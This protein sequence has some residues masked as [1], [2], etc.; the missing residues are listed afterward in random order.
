[1]AQNLNGSNVAPA[2]NIVKVNILRA[3][4]KQTK[5]IDTDIVF[6]LEDGRTVF[7]RDGAVQS[8]LDNGFSVEFSDGDQV[9]GQELLQSAGSAEISSVAL[10][11]PQASSDNN[12]IV[13][14]APQA[15]GTSAAAAPSSGG[16]LK[17]WLA[18]GTPLVG[19]VLGGVLGGGGGGGSAA[20]GG[21]TD[22]TANVKPATPV[23]NVV[24]NDDKVNAAEKDATAGVAV[25]G[26]AEANASVTVNWGSTSKT[27]TADSAG[28]WSASFAKAEVPADAAGT[29]ISAIV[30]STAGVSSDPATRTVQ[31]D[32]TA[33]DAPVI[34]GSAAERIVGPTEK[35]T[36][37][38]FTGTAEAGSTVTVSFAGVS[39]T[40]V[41]DAGGGWSV[42]YKPNEVPNPVPTAYPVT[43]TARDA[44]GNMSAASA[45]SNVKVTP[46]IDVL[47][48]I[49]AGPV[50]SGNGLSVDIYRANGTLLV[51]GI[52]V[53]ADGSFIAKELPIVAGDVIFARVVD[54]TTAADYLDEATGVATDLNAVLLAVTVVE[55][56]SVTMNI[57]PL[58]TIAAIK[59]GLA[60][61]GSGTIANAAAATNAN[62][63]TAQAFGL[64]GIDIT[65]TS[66]VATNSDGYNPDDGLTPGE[67]VGAVLA[68]LSGL[69]SI[70]AG[71]SQTTITNLSQSVN[72]DGNKGQLDNPGQVLLM[73]G[74]TAAE[75]K[76]QGSLQNLISDSLA[77]SS[78]V[79]QV[80]INAIATDN[81]IAGTEV[82]NLT[83]SGTVSSGA[84]GVTVLM[85]TKTSEA[86]VSGT[87][88]SYTLS[89][90]DISALGA[91]GVKVIQA[92]ATLPNAASATASR[93]VT[94]KIA[95]PAAP[96]LNV[97]SGDNAINSVE[98]TAGVA[99]AGTGEVGSTVFLTFGSVTKNVLVDAAA[100]TWATAFLASE[101]PADG[102]STV[103]VVAKDSFGNS[104]AAVTRSIQI[105]SSAP[106][107]PIIKPVAGDDL[108]GPSEKLAGVQVQGTAEALANIS[109]TFGNFVRTAKADTLG[110]WSVSI[111][112]SQVPE[113]GEILVTVTQ[114]DAAGNVSAAG[115]R[116]VT[117]DAQ[118]PAK[119]VI[120]NVATD[121]IINAAEKQN[122]VF[123]RG[124][125][126][127]NASI[128]ITFGTIIRSAK[129]SATGTWSASFTPAQI[130]AD[131]T[132]NVTAIATD[133][134]GNASESATRSFTIDTVNQNL[135]IAPV[136][137]DN[138]INAAEK[139]ANVTVTGQAEPGAN[140]VVTLGGISRPASTNQSGVW[141]ATF[142]TTE[143]PND[144]NLT[145]VTAQS[146]DQ[147]GNISDVAKQDI[148]IDTVVPGTPVISTVAGDDLINVTERAG[149]I[150]VNGTAE[151]GLAVRVTWNDIV[152]N[153][154]ASTLGAWSAIFTSAE[155]PSDGISTITARA[156]DAAGNANAVDGTRSVTTLTAALQPPI[157]D[158][159]AGDD[160]I[161]IAERAAGVTVT[162]TASANA[163]VE[164]T[165][166]STTRVVDAN[167]S[168][169]W[170]AN[171]TTSQVAAEGAARSITAFQTDVSG[172]VSGTRTRNVEVDLTEPQVPVIISPIAVDNIINA[173]EKNAGVTIS[174]TAPI[175]T[176]VEVRI[177]GGTPKSLTSSG[178]GV[179]SVTFAGGD[180]PA[181]ATGVVIEA[182]TIDAAGNPSVW[183]G[184]PPVIINTVPVA[185]PTGLD[186][187][188]VDDTG[189]S[190]SDNVTNQTSALTISGQAEANTRVELFNG[191]T[192]LGST[193]ADASGAFSFDVTLAP[194]AR[195]I[196]AK[197]IDAVGNV[198][199]ASAALAITVDATAPAA[200]K[201][202]DLATAPQLSAITSGAGGFVINGA[203][204]DDRSGF[205]VSS[206]GD[207]NND[208]FDDLIIGAPD[209]DP[210][211]NISGASYVVFGKANNST[212]VNLSAIA[213][214]IG[215]FVIN[216]ASVDDN[217]G[218]SVSSAG[219]VNNDGFDD[220][221][222]G[223]TGAGAS[224]GAS[225]VVFGK[226]NGT[227]VNLSA[228][229]TGGFVI[230]GASADVGLGR[231]VSSAGDV[232]NDGYD[233][234]IIGADRT[235]ANGTSYSGASYV[236][237]GKANNTAVNLSAIGT[238]G[239]VIDGVSAD[240]RS[241]YSVSS[242]GDVNGDGFDDLIIGAPN[243]DL[244]GNSSGTSYVVFGKA[245]NMSVNLS[246]IASG[247]G[248]FVINGASGED[249]SGFSVSSAGDVNGDGLD[250]LIIGAPNADPNG[251]AYAGASYVVFGKANNTAPVNLSAI[252]SGTGGF[253]INGALADDR[254]GRSVGSAGDV[255][256]DGL[257]DLIIG[258]LY[259][260]PNGN[261]DA[262]ASYVV[263]GKA[264]GTPVNLSA[265]GTGGFVI[266]GASASDRSG[267][268]VSSAGDLNNDGFDDLIIGA[269]Y[270]DPNGRN[271]SGAS[272]V[273]FGGNFT[274]A[275][276][277]GLNLAAADD[278]GPSN[279]DNVTS[280]SSGLTITG[281]AEANAR[282]QLFDGTTSLGTTTASAAGAFSFDVTLDPGTRSIT[283]RATDAA[284]N[285][286]A[287]SAALAITV[288]PTA[289]NAPTGLDLAA[290]DD[291]GASNSDNVTSQSSG[292]T[293]SGQAEAN[294]RIELF[295]GTTSLGR[296]TANASGAFSL[297][298]TL[299]AGTR[300]ITAKATD[301]AGNV[302]AASAALTIT[303]DG[304]A[305][306]APTDLDLIAA[307][308][309]GASSTDN[310]TNKQNVTITGLAAV[311]ARV[312][313]FDGATS[314]GSAT[315][316]ATTGAFSL[317]VTL[318]PGARSITAKATDAS[319]NVSAASAALAI[320]V[321]ATA[322]NAP[323][324]L[325]LAAADDS[326][327]DST[328]NVTSQTSALTISGQAEANARVELFDGTTSL[329][330]TTAS[331]TGAFSLDVTLA[332][333]ARSI[334]AR[335][336]DA[337]GNV[338]AASAALA[339]TVDATAP[340][341]PTALDLAAADD[342]G[343]DSTDNV[344]SQTSALTISGQA[345]ANARVE[346]FNGTTSLGT[347]TANAS[348]A[349]SLD[350][351]LAAGA[352]AITAK[353][354][355]AA[356]NVSAA[357]AAL[358]ITVDG[359]APAAP[360][361]LDLAAAD[362]TG[363]SNSDNLTNQTSALTI[364]GQ[365]EANARVQLFDGTTSLGT[366]TANAS[367]AFSL[368]VT[369]AAGARSITAR[370]TD[371]AGNVGAAS[372][373]LAITVDVT[374]PDVPAI[375]TPIAVDNTINAVEKNAG[376]N[377]SGTAPNSTTVEVRI[378][379][380]TPK[381]VT[382]S[383][384]GAWSVTFAS[385]EIPADATGVIIEA[386]TIDTAGN[387]SAWVGAPPVII[388]TVAPAA[389][390]GLDLAA[391][392]DSGSDSTDN[393][394]NQTSALT[395][396]G[397]AAANALI[398]LFDGATSLGTA[399]ADA[400]TGAFSFDVTLAEGPRSITARAI[401]EA[402]NVSAASAALSV[403]ID[404]LA[405]PT[406]VITGMSND[407]GT[408]GD[409]RTDR[410]AVVL[411][412]TGVANG[413]VELSIPGLPTALLDV[414]SAGLWV[415]PVISLATLAFN[416]SVTA[417]VRAKDAAGNVSV[418]DASQVIT[419]ASTVS[420]PIDLALSTA[421]VGF[422]VESA[423]EQDRNNGFTT[424]DIN[425]DGHKDL[426]LNHYFGGNST[427]GAV[428]VLYG[429]SDWTG[430][431]SF[432]LLNL[433]NN[434]YVLRGTGANDLLGAGGSGFIGDLN[435]DGFGELIVGAPNA[436]SSSLG[437]SG[438]AYIVWGSNQLLGTLVGNRYIKDVST[439][440]P[441]EGF[442]FRGLTASE[443]MGSATLG[444]SSRP[445][446]NSDFNGDGLAD[447]FIGA[448]GYDKPGG[449][450]HGGI[451]VVFGRADRAY[452]SVNVTTGQQ[453]MTVADLTADKGFIIVG[454]AQND[455]VGRSIA[456]AG[457]VNGDGVTDLLIG[458][459][460][461]DRGSFSTAGAA[462]V[463]YGKKTPEGQ[464]TWSG[465]VN[466]PLM[467]GRKI[468]DL[469]ALKTEDGFM[470][471][472]EAANA[473]F[474]RS[475]EG[476]G[477][478]NGDGFGDIIVSAR[479][480]TVGGVGNA[481]KAYVIFG[482]ATG[483]GD[484]AGG[485]Q[486]L[487]IPAMTSSQ[488]FTIQG[489][490]ATNAR[491]G[492]SVGAAGDV[493]GDGLADIMVTSP[494]FVNPRT[495]QGTGA[496][497]IIYGKNN[498]EGWGQTV[499]T[500]SILDLTNFGSSDGFVVY[501][502]G[503]G[504]QLGSVPGDSSLIAP[505][506]LN[507]DGVDDLFINLNESD[508]G[509][510]YNN[511]AGA[512]VYGTRGFGGLTLT[513]TSGGD[514]L[515]GGG[516]ADTINGLGGLDRLSG[517][518]GNDTLIVGDASF[519]RV[520]GGAGTDTLRMAGTSGFD[521]NLSTLAAGTIKD[522]EVI[523]L[524]VAGSLNNILTVTQQTLLDLSTTSN[525]LTVLGGSGDTVNAAG[526]AT[527]GSIIANGINYTV[528]NSGAAT[529]WVQSGVTVVGATPQSSGYV[530]TGFGGDDTL[531][532][533]DTSFLSVDGG[534]GT[535]TLRM[536]GTSGFDLNLSTLAA[537]AIKD[538]EVIDLVVAGSLNNS[539]TVTQQTL[540]DLSTTSNR[541]TVLGGSGDTVNATGF[542]A[543]SAQTVNGI[544]YN[545]YTSGLAELWV[546]SGVAVVTAV[547]PV[548]F[549]PSAMS[550]TDQADFAAFAPP[551]ESSFSPAISWT[552]QAV[553]AV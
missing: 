39:K 534:A 322:P 134:S 355:D 112:S 404:T 507:N 436:D 449:N 442:V 476:L 6:V 45:I 376:V 495:N 547:P 187:D 320:T 265:I 509:G 242:A 458:G 418:S 240:D 58:T 497:F 486:I 339:I 467:A 528:Y 51:S 65:T 194:G 42:K 516:L 390:T 393:V 315:A 108:I 357:S 22:T 347:A 155:Q 523:D 450:N 52:K 281:Q 9:S 301:A 173:V 465:L 508:L 26:I 106:G 33:P 262:G 360:T 136:A 21:G 77:A 88:W 391:A 346:L 514:T 271:N 342:S 156:T 18:I 183:V 429:R 532:V 83:L 294:A 359:T 92:Q 256:G 185:A 502:K 335:A 216:G 379:G 189:L 244:N 157:I 283:A 439:I 47:G 226:A 297:D 7:I 451:I 227:A 543:G 498:G 530:L 200:P 375:T 121:N 455:Q 215:G 268:S 526:F 463:I 501:S 499:G 166:G 540:L 358:T 295:D 217:S 195:A 241:G 422:I 90:A 432:D 152:K 380:G 264:N 551:P 293:I 471:W 522:I 550:W 76:V 230:N 75:D 410:N 416:S 459:Q 192:S 46:A 460:D 480:S 79:T 434:G 382:S 538:I 180:I 524:V 299:A 383:G 482:S 89:A 372:A 345:E 506:D 49:V 53:N 86:S 95:P 300:A 316:D 43:A 333:G 298:V 263:F 56:T 105:D 425:G 131:G 415:S 20:T 444:I 411:T 309:S 222:I 153:V 223:A 239:F 237:F 199:A 423:I 364:S 457:D 387:P 225:Y 490:A 406:A 296:A 330:T 291:T 117:V 87:S 102:N 321:D 1:M 503:N 159:V 292:L 546:Q 275:A 74:A 19:G 272:Y 377:I 93:L 41:A 311:N 513:G 35:A 72:V 24:A 395:I 386:R 31:I 248:G 552:D 405:P 289:P 145:T 122:G 12:A 280:Q 349:F 98:K 441:S 36:G 71:N 231:S 407:Y 132:A 243:T 290:A 317:G 17:T 228:I 85:G 521:L 238:G 266:N 229:G 186:L 32:A 478:I 473:A 287:A 96:S 325:D 165:F 13:V 409:F 413:Q 488:G 276:P 417:T 403:T 512:F 464:Q 160:R 354:T 313:L 2:K 396:S 254:L 456:S 454:G 235:N 500:Q 365:A 197:A 350:V 402:G 483:Q 28:R 151:A 328:D 3:N 531:I 318:D 277:T 314:L 69:D 124:T 82:A 438:A 389:P 278:T 274:G 130:P 420:T 139:S 549:V 123:I 437:N 184:A 66:V 149:N 496:A 234:L 428:T 202:F 232:N 61:D 140:V 440:T 492:E 181:D 111:P 285:V 489:V 369:L 385:G 48:Q 10:T 171:F 267:F 341:A 487:S 511:G 260:D 548:G 435:G 399:T 210:N 353:A 245:N 378:G 127:P 484:I 67:K 323:T 142:S 224:Y 361:G 70:N 348:G 307:D 541:L 236:V 178:T 518:D 206:A 371:A 252:A 327:S 23:I 381:S 179:W 59:A 114:S 374:A 324:A 203:L 505:G 394:T 144:T 447:F 466:D 340:N 433:G 544:T 163:K 332:A 472:G 146:T 120:L 510:R 73:R 168:G 367:G 8:L 308:D 78:P 103:S 162:G 141:V 196:T 100:G 269:P 310:L 4:V 147:A 469:G 257:D 57:N 201:G 167:G 63:A 282:V 427:L 161:S 400:T 475:V 553:L 164:V 343:S 126:E 247:T 448:F 170:T 329:G 37:V 344:T 368:D 84:T 419:K 38:E 138:V 172:N 462:Y 205:S 305:P 97:V 249:N 91:D 99:F 148:R 477:D 110:N 479:D 392:D 218:F 40:D 169:V 536:A 34:A 373:A 25:S 388:N 219:D 129:A 515:N 208:G 430:V 150:T 306:A 470:I 452:G 370:A 220:L 251:N 412:G 533:G 485:R 337:A 182:R 176:V 397:Q 158:E 109:L 80:T 198:S 250:D 331:G 545:T 175:S 115:T 302:S 319:G 113:V 116:T 44:N 258:A 62:T 288:D 517:F 174:G 246:A 29:T 474:G 128:E 362:D 81:I 504:D 50:Q 68:A 334:T 286:G 64:S 209:A 211:G 461:V 15:T 107:L 273:V 5:V 143:I 284:G 279:S 414:D 537:G 326:G 525:R 312:E 446:A 154:T 214:G 27:V 520:D 60:A 221:I 135:T 529:L 493:N 352:R 137:T 207:V 491:L 204:A 336:T 55:G 408:L 30:K 539:L 542:T 421:A 453:E 101:I 519:V 14:Q 401:D 338:S 190:N 54:S 426:I 16:G 304:T 94:L 445:G 193:T 535:D 212:P 133:A 188:A 468:L 233:D 527:S 494:F 351:T 253:V 11:G 424:G 104:S 356:G 384:T 191:A 213:S 398:E 443:T 177:G 270:A 366:A 119:P 118:P 125:A 255:N 481:G 261:Q 303:V 431:A 259:A 363:S